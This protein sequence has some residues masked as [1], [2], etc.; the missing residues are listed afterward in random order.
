MK[1]LLNRRKSSAARDKG[2]RRTEC[3]F[4]S[5]EAAKRAKKK[6]LTG[7]NRAN[8]ARQGRNQILDFRLKR[9]KPYPAHNPKSA[10]ILIKSF[11][12]NHDRN[13]RN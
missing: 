7:A 10:L 2:E 5:S 1:A 4:I 11:G 12:E 3:R 13:L 6:S 8:T 9:K